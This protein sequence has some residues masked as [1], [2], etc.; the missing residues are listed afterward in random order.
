MVENT[1]V[2]VAQSTEA[3]VSLMRTSADE[4]RTARALKRAN[5]KVIHGMPRMA[6]AVIFAV[7]MKKFVACTDQIKILKAM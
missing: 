5:W 2:A 4:S 6:L 1:N 3:S 7:P